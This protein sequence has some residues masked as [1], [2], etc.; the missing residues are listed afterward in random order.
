MS[1]RPGRSE[2][3]FEVAY[4]GSALGVF[5]FSTVILPLMGKT[6]HFGVAFLAICAAAFPSKEFRGLIRSWRRSG[7]SE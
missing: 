3:V 7:S 6:P 2:F 4:R 5:L 1:E